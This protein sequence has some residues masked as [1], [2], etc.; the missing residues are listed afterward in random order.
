LKGRNRNWIYILLIVAGGLLILETFS[1]YSYS[2][3]WNLGVLLPGM[4]G[5]ALIVIALRPLLFYVIYCRGSQATG[6]R[7]PV[8]VV[9]SAGNKRSLLYHITKPL[10]RRI[11]IILTVVLT[12]CLLIFIIVEALIIMDPYLHRS[13]LAGEV[14]YLIVLGAGIWPDGRPTLALSYRLDEAI[15]YYNSHGPLRIIVSGGQ[16]A[17]EPFAE[18]LAMSLYLQDRGIPIE[19]ILVEDRSTSTMENFKFSRQLIGEAVPEPI[20][21]VFI[22]NDFHVLRSRILAKRNGFEAY[23]IPAPTPYV[24]LINSYLREFFAFVKSMLVDY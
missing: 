2:S 24:V 19:D 20:R 11:R 17:N 23:A 16:G 15:A 5:A 7:G 9:T 22:T 12:L 4:I 1:A 13:E 6:N 8:A 10:D 18:A 3:D 14:D 21:I